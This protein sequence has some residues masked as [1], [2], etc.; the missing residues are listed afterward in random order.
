[1]ST[2]GFVYDPPA[3]APTHYPYP[4]AYRAPIHQL[5]RKWGLDPPPP[6]TPSSIQHPQTS[7]SSTPRQ[8]SSDGPRG[9]ER[10]RAMLNPFFTHP[11]R[12]KEMVSQ[13][14][15][16]DSDYVSE[17]EPSLISQSPDL[18]PPHS[19]LRARNDSLYS[20]SLPEETQKRLNASVNSMNKH[21]HGVRELHQAQRVLQVPHSLQQEETQRK[22]H[23]TKILKTNNRAAQQIHRPWE[24]SD[25]M[26]KARSRARASDSQRDQTTKQHEHDFLPSLMP[27][28]LRATPHE[29]KQNMRQEDKAGSMSKNATQVMQAHRDSGLLRRVIREGPHPQEDYFSPAL[30]SSRVPAYQ[31]DSGALA[32]TFARKETRRMTRRKEWHKDKVKSAREKKQ[33][34][35]ASPEFAPIF[36]SSGIATLGEGLS[37]A[38]PI[39]L[40]LRDL[41]PYWQNRTIISPHN[42]TPKQMPSSLKREASMPVQQQIGKRRKPTPKFQA[43][44]HVSSFPTLSISSRH[45]SYTISEDYTKFAPRHRLTALDGDRK[46]TLF[47]PS[48]QSEI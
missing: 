41:G 33:Y 20:E 19:L 36:S 39:S 21:M 9:V 46:R 23:Q 16:Q 5:R 14:H 1:M 18:H 34:N 10:L 13:D 26:A 29:R 2:L 6:L 12:R 32:T 17:D 45:I 40:T 31:Q 4:P 35:E 7:S 24:D 47:N 11:S 43:V 28:P 48:K 37:L 38:P 3:Q 15:Q 42:A 22:Q 30:W 8:S 27:Q 25:G 44:S